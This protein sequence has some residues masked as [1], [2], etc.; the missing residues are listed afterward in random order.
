MLHRFH[1]IHTNGSRNF[2]IYTYKWVPCF[3]CFICIELMFLHSSPLNN[4]ISVSISTKCL[5]NR[6]KCIHFYFTS[7]NYHYC[8]PPS[9]FLIIVIFHLHSLSLSLSHTLSRLLPPHFVRCSTTVRQAS[10]IKIL[11]DRRE[12]GSVVIRMSNITQLDVTSAKE[13]L[14]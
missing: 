8:F 9:F 5:P 4:L 14:G 6:A 2:F 12:D 13:L 1:Y 10:N 3:V 11:D 7:F